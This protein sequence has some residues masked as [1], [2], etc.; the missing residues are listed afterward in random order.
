LKSPAE[1]GKSTNGYRTGVVDSF[2]DH[3]TPFE[4]PGL[5]AADGVHLSE[6]GKSTFRHRLAKL[7]KRAL[8]YSCWGRGTSIHS[9]PTSLMPVPAIDAQSLEEDHRRASKG[10]HKRNFMHSSQ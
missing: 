7:V 3:R 10:Q 2:L 1:S 9:T 6:K 5:A 8:N 4:K